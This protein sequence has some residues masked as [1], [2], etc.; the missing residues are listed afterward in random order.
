MAPLVAFKF[1]DVHLST[2]PLLFLVAPTQKHGSYLLV[3]VFFWS[4]DEVFVVA[5][6]AAV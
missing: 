2:S 4:G 3:L 5:A 6:V 1:I